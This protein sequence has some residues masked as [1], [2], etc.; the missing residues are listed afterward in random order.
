MKKPLK[1]ALTVIGT[2]IGSWLI[3]YAIFVFINV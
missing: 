3:G 1:Y 2:V